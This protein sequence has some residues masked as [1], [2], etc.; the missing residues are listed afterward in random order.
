MVG[1][2]RFELPTSRSRTV[3]SRK[4]AALAGTDSVFSAFRENNR[5]AVRPKP[6]LFTPQLC[7]NRALSAL[8]LACRR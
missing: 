3:R 5:G 1:V 7:G 6:A 4:R 8:L 2:G